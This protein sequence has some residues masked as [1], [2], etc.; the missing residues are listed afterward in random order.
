M[1]SRG[2]VLQWKN[3]EYRNAICNTFQADSQEHSR[4]PT[5]VRKLID[6]MFL[7][8]PRIELFAREQTNRLDWD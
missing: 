8:V 1:E 5:Y 7:N 3:Q 2:N 6:K 4:K